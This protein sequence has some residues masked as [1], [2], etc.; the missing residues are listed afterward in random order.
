MN[1][2]QFQGT[3]SGAVIRVGQG[4]EAYWSFLPN[5]LPPALDMTPQLVCQLSEADRAL[6][7]LAGLARNLSNPQLLIGPFVKREAV[8]SSRIEGTQAN[9]TDLYAYEAKQLSMFSP[10]RAPDPSDVREVYNYVEA[11]NYGLSRLNSLP[12]SLRLTRELHQRLLRGVRG[13]HLTPG[14]FRR[15]PNWIGGTGLN[16]AIFVPPPVDQMNSSLDALEKYL[17]ARGSYP[18]LV[19]LALIHYQFEA[20]HPFLD[21]NGRVGRLLISLLLVHWNLLPLPL[22]Y[23]SAY[24]EKHRQ[25]YYQLLLAVSERAAWTEW[26]GFFLEGVAEQSRDAISRVK[27]LQDLKALWHQALTQD[28]SSGLQFRLIDSL[29]ESPI[30]TVPGARQ[31]LR[32]SYP[33]AK[34]NVL[35]LVE[36]KILSTIRG[37]SN[38]K[39]YAAREI[40]RIARGD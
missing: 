22:L 19:R 39:V 8:L 20:I 37:S 30:L 14:E 21:G 2:E 4:Q 3:S 34:L 1:P 23:L 25:K 9:V 24:F 15:T 5:P 38:P 13:Q 11:L 12:V 28:R 6:G 32:C 26:T 29:F 35:K 7:E 31:L 10:G 36:R 18:P 17:H 27:R 16:D 33:A 40:L